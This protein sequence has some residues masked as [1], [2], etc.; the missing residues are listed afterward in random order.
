M[1]PPGFVRTHSQAAEDTNHNKHDQ[2]FGTLDNSF[3]QQHKNFHETLELDN[4]MERDDVLL[5]EGLLNIFLKPNC[6]RHVI[7]YRKSQILRSTGSTGSR[8]AYKDA[9]IDFGSFK[10]TIEIDL[11]D[12]Y[13]TSGGAELPKSGSINSSPIYLSYH[14]SPG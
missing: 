11:S 13:T 8:P 12:Q 14:N 2:K 4:F 9:Y 1:S 10:E 6:S 5:C 7:T 3:G